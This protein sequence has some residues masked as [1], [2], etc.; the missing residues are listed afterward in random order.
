M[1]LPNIL[2][3]IGD[4]NP[5][6]TIQNDIDI[7]YVLYAIWLNDNKWYLRRVQNQM[8]SKRK[9]PMR[10]D[11]WYTLAKQYYNNELSTN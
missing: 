2:S 7:K 8:N 6:F 9:T 5:G 4:I 1:I 3:T 10:F 11:E